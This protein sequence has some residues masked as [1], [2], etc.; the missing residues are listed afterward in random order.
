MSATS[1]IIHPG[2]LL[3]SEIT[4]QGMN[5]SELA[6]RTGVSAKHIS[7]IINGTKEI[8]VS[9]ARKLDVALGAE[10]GTWAKLQADYDIYMA[11]LKEKNDITAEEINIFNG[12]KEIVDY[13]LKIGFMYNNCGVPEKIIQL[14]KILCVA[15]LTVI[16]KITYNAAYRAQIN[17]STNID[18]Y[19]LFAWQRICELQTNN[20]TISAHFD[21]GLLLESVPLIKKQMFETDPMKMISNLKSIFSA[22]GVA[23]DVVRHFRGAPVQGFIKETNSGKVILCVTIRGKSADKFWFSLFHEIGHLVAGDLGTRFVD[24]D[25]VQNGMEVKADNYARDTLI[26]SKRYKSFIST[27][28]YHSLEEIKRF[29]SVVGVP[30]WIVIG[31]LHKDEWLDW[32]YFAHETPAFEWSN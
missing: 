23:F 29:S 26:D 32:K 17:T 25:S 21:K 16:P 14:R 10:T 9:F 12:M 8:S 2:E 30:H 13:F 3:L 27:K 28:K 7:T 19:I 5:Q 4:K 1:R 18:P 31:R 22:C 11:E 24:F 6:I 15:S 20:A